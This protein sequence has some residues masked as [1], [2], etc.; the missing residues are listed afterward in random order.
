LYSKRVKKYNI[1]TEIKGECSKTAALAFSVY[2]KGKGNRQF[3]IPGAI[4]SQS[5][6]V[7]DWYEN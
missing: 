3:E 1:Y 7:E 5:G 6:I 4:S 2:G